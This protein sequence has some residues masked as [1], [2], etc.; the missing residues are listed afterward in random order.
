M[1]LPADLI[2][3]LMPPQCRKGLGGEN[4]FPMAWAGLDRQQPDRPPMAQK[5][6]EQPGTF[7]ATVLVYDGWRE[8]AGGQPLLYIGEGIQ[9]YVS[10]SCFYMSLSETAAA[11]CRKTPT[12]TADNICEDDNPQSEIPLI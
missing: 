4:G 9:R 2:P 12:I 5:V 8:L 10:Y 3:G 11:S 1:I 6:I 7:Q